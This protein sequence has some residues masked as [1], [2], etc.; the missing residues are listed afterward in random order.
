MLSHREQ[1]AWL[2]GVLIYTSATSTKSID[3][4]PVLAL[5]GE[6]RIRK[7]FPS[8]PVHWLHR[9][10]A[11][12]PALGRTFHFGLGLSQPLLELLL[13]EESLQPLLVVVDPVDRANCTVRQPPPRPA[14]GR[15]PWACPP[16]LP[17]ATPAALTGSSHRG[18]GPRGPS[19]RSHA[20]APLG[21]QRHSSPG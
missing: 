19:A 3:S 2:A 4:H 16:P 12:S 21:G 13:E 10:Q 18:S 6:S 8:V 1:G 15:P 5:G 17:P 20:C 9:P 11:C 7:E 14:P